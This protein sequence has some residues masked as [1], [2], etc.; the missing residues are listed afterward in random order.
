MRVGL[1]QFPDVKYEPCGV[2][3]NSEYNSMTKF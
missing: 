2:V 3:T 1:I